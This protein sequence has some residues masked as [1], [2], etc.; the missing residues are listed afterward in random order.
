MVAQ[1]FDTAIASAELEPQGR[2]PQNSREQDLHLAG[3]PYVGN[4][5]SE[6]PD[7]LI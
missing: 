3:L 2:S 4:S 6:K 7:E 1:S 5:E